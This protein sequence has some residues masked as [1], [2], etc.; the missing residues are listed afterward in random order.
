MAEDTSIMIDLGDP[1]AKE[2]AEVIGNKTANKILDYLASSEGTVSDIS[3]DLKIPLNTVD[4]NIK[5]MLKAGLIEKSSH[6]WSVKG[7]K[8]P[9]YKVSNRKIIISP[10]KSAAKTFAWI[11]GVTGL[12]ALTVRE[13]FGKTLMNTQLSSGSREAA[14]LSSENISEVAVES[15]TGG[16]ASDAVFVGSEK[17]LSEAAMAEATVVAT[18]GTSC[19]FSTL[20]PWQWFLLGAW[21]AILLFF[22]VT[23]IKNRR[24]N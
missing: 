10:R 13:F 8:M 12:A 21:F 4:Y 5:K 15:A 22:V 9:T 23:L 11:I 7:K 16:V 14:V 20:G 1:K 19:I 18:E 3:R 24:H 2:I 17:M 6:W